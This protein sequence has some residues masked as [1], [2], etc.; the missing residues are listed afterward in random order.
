LIG[1]YT[2]ERKV[3]EKMGR[4]LE[5]SFRSFGTVFQLFVSFVLAELI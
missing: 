1:R 3:E 5:L 2:T 4:V